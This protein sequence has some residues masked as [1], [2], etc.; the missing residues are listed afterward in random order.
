MILTAVAPDALHLHWEWVRAGLLECRRRGGGHDTPEDIYTMCK[1]GAAHLY[2]IGDYGFAVLQRHKD[3]DGTVLFILAL[4]CQPRR[5]TFDEVMGALDDLARSI[6]CVRI[7]MWSQRNWLRL[8]KS[9]STV[10][11]RE[12]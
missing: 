5:G 11:E 2:R 8:F 3:S 12:V 7:R 4:W 1:S 9:V 6:G 10:Y